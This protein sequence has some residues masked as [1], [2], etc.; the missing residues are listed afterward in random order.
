MRL[1]PRLDVQVAIEGESSVREEF[2]TSASGEGERMTIDAPFGWYG[3]WCVVVVVVVVCVCV[4][5]GRDDCSRLSS[6]ACSCSTTS[7]ERRY[8]PSPGSGRRGSGRGDIRKDVLQQFARE[9][10]ETVRRLV[11]QEPLVVIVIAV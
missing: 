1:N 7:S 4:R 8:D 11:E 9:A 5:T 10:S 3:G 2:A 6:G